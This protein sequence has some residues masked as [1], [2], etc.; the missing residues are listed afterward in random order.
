[1]LNKSPMVLR[2]GT[3][4]KSV[5]GSTLQGWQGELQMSTDGANAGRLWICPTTE[6][7][8]VSPVGGVTPPTITGSR[9][10]GTAL[11]NLLTQLAALGII[12][13]STTS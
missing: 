7:A 12:V 8:F 13:D 11:A 1:M 3:A 10:D 9:G 6:S 5:L 4:T 2:V